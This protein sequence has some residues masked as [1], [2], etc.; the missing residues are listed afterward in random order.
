MKSLQVTNRNIFPVDSPKQTKVIEIVKNTRYI[1]A[2]G[3]ES[4]TKEINHESNEDNNNSTI[5]ASTSILVS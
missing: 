3:S 4:G 1:R 2:N 5:E